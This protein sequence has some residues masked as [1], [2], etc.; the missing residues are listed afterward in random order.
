MAF[1]KAWQNLNA[2]V[3]HEACGKTSMHA[4]PW[5]MKKKPRI[6]YHELLFFCC[7]Y[8]KLIDQQM[9]ESLF[10]A[11]NW[12]KDKA[13]SAYNFVADKVSGVVTSAKDVVTTIHQDARDLVG[14]AGGIVR[15]TEKSVEN[16]AGKYVDNAASTI[17]N[18]GRNAEG[19]GASLSNMAMPLAIFQNHSFQVLKRRVSISGC[20]IRF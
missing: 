18:L 2:K 16:F 1:E 9:F 10:S 6:K 7:F 19:I 15:D 13:V 3:L 11:Y 4:P 12:V 8:I 20:S 14:G 17:S 5:L